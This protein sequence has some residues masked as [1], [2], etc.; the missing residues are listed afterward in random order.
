MI[1]IHVRE[2]VKNDKKK[3]II[4]EQPELKEVNALKYE[5]QLFVDAVLNDKNPVVD[6]NDGL[7]ALKVAELIVNEIEE[8]QAN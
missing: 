3:E 2:R 8:S 5:L 7:K 4:Y 1:S 6:G